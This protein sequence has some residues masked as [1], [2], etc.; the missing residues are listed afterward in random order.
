VRVV[1]DIEQDRLLREDSRNYRLR[2]NLPAT[3]DL[4]VGATQGYQG[5]PSRPIWGDL[6]WHTRWCA[7]HPAQGSPIEGNWRRDIPAPIVQALWASAT[8]SFPLPHAVDNALFDWRISF[9][10]RCVIEHNP[11]A[12]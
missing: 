11:E 5:H 6:M 7:E 8:Q 9:C 4:F 1:N 12:N 10:R 2:T 3:L